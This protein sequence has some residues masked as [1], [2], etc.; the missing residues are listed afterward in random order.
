VAQ[1]ATSAT[2]FAEPDAGTP[3][4]RSESQLDV[5]EIAPVLTQDP[6]IAR[7]SCPTIRLA[8]DLEL[9]G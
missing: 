1:A 4:F 5:L 3:K 9:V 8:S 7:T 6:R 2:G